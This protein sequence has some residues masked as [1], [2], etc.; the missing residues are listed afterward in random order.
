MDLLQI[1][2]NKYGKVQLK[3]DETAEAIGRSVFSLRDDRR[4]GIGLNYI[5][6]GK[7][8]SGKI[9]YPLEEIVNYLQNN[10]IQTA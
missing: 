4:K 3:P 5:K 7:G 8:Q 6:I 2:F 10:T 1:L 9:Y